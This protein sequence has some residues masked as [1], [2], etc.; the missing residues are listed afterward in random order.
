MSN[1]ERFKL[2]MM[3]KPVDRLPMIEWAT[4]WDKTLERWYSEGLP[5][6]LI[7]DG[8]IREYFGLD[9]YRQIWIRAIGNNCPAPKTYGAG[10]I[11]DIKEYK[12]IKKYLYPKNFFDN[13]F[14]ILE[15]WSEKQK[16]GDMVIWI[17]LDGFFWFPRQLFGI[18]QHLFAFYDKEELMHQINSDL[19]EFHLW[20]INEFC[21]ICTPDFMTFAEDMSYNNGPMLSKKCFDKFLA[22]YYHNIIPS[23]KKKGI[24][25]FIDS[26]GNIFQMIKWI[27]RV[28]IEG[29]L[30]L[31]RRAGTDIIKIRE[32]FPKFK[33]I[34]GFDKTVMSQGEKM[35][36]Q[37]FERIFPIM[38]QGGY[39]PSVDHQTPPDVSLKQ[40][41]CYVSLLKEYCEKATKVYSDIYLH[42]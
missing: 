24:I 40:Y 34:G 22:P 4:W 27:E 38:S 39:I 6:I 31:E 30:P 41:H 19:V 36:R 29:G 23:L 17:T 11:K 1:R 28:G 7:D 8:E 35:M 13:I 25:P 37:E 26:D 16:K 12:E 5:S 10:L 18:E 2:T 15:K 20:A 33:M 42:K 14:P 32:F 9:C 3:F 21:K